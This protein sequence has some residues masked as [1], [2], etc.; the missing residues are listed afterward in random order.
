MLPGF[1]LS[2]VRCRDYLFSHEG[3]RRDTKVKRE[4]GKTAF[5]LASLR[6]PSWLDKGHEGE[7]RGRENGFF[8]SVTSRTFVAK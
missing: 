8:L 2:V 3:T 5:S 6:V 4:E 1:C 7:E